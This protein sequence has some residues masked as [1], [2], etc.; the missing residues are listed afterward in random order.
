MARKKTNKKRTPHDFKT[1]KKV[2]NNARKPLLNKINSLVLWLAATGILAFIGGFT[3]DFLTGDV[4]V[5]F[6]KPSG[7]GYEFK[8]INN[9]STDQIIKKFRVSPDLEQ[10]V[11]F[12]INKDIYAEVNKSGVSLPGG[13]TSYVPAYEYK[14]MNGY[15]L[16]A[17]S[18]INFRI[19]PLVARDYMVPEYVIVYV[20]YETTSKNVYLEKVESTLKDLHLIDLS[21]RKRYFVVDNYWTPIGDGNII[22]AI[23]TACR[24]DDIFAKSES[25]W[26]Y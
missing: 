11:I 22:N 5:K 2:K 6:I 21:Q 20:E 19:P 25:C 24:D 4:Q 18:D 9:S 23:K 3:Y 14:E 17:K 13:N 10:E 26:S 12:K 16:N 15:V 7:R 1:K 8:L